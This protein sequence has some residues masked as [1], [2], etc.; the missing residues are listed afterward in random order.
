[1]RNFGEKE[2]WA[3]PGTAQFFRVPPIISGTAKA[4]IF[5]FCTHIYRLNGNKSPL[6]ISGKVAGKGTPENFQG[7]HTYGASRGHLCDSSA[8]L[9]FIIT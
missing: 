7:T 5:K 1:M 8:F 3:Y 4:A 9:F 2:A 6:K